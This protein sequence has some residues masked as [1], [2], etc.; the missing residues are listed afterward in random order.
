[1]STY[2]IEGSILLSAVRALVGLGLGRADST[3][4]QPVLE[5][6]DQVACGDFR[7]DFSALEDV[8]G[9]VE[10]ASAELVDPLAGF[11]GAVTVLS[12]DVS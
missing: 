12:I 10:I 6:V 4:L 3:T 7:E 5:L 9:V 2:R 1:M 11:K 8:A